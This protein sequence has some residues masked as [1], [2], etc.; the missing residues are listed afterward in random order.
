MRVAAAVVILTASLVFLAVRKTNAERCAEA[1]ARMQELWWSAL[2]CTR[3][4][5]CYY[6]PCT[7]GVIGSS[8]AAQEYIEL[9]GWRDDHCQRGS[10]AYC[11][12][13]GL[14]CVSGLCRVLRATD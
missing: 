3:D 7:C 2:M 1:R 14:R 6:F 8:P 11:G 5:D 13:T 9:Y 10:L 12:T 4:S